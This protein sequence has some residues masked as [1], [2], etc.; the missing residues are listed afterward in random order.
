MRTAF[1]GLGV[2]GFPMAGY[3]S[4]AGH[5]TVVFNRTASRAAEWCAGNEGASAA[6]PAAAAQDADI[7]FTCV[8]NDDDVREVILGDNGILQNMS[9]GSVIVDHTTAS[10]TIARSVMFPNVTPLPA[11]I[12]R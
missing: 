3:L 10:A 8:G 7:A 12:P 4:R 11:R 6:T 5:E 2:M 9:P 1:I